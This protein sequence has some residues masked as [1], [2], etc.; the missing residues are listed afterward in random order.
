MWLHVLLPALCFFFC[1]ICL[2]GLY[3]YIYTGRPAYIGCKILWNISRWCLCWSWKGILHPYLKRS[4]WKFKSLEALS[5]ELRGFKS[6]TC[7]FKPNK[8]TFTFNQPEPEFMKQTPP[9]TDPNR[10]H[11]MLCLISGESH[12][13]IWQDLSSIW[14]YNVAYTNIHI[15][16]IHI[17]IYIYISTVK[18]NRYYVI[19]IYI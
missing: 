14:R 4:L 7:S 16:T 6:D 2:C 18:C 12:M 1:N 8:W 3:I 15:H 10:S 13:S 9:L 17:Y 11:W 5:K 19:Y